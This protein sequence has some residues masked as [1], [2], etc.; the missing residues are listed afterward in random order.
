MS[1]S[2]V[3][4]VITLSG[5]FLNLTIAISSVVELLFSS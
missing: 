2:R 4:N 3:F 5:I 1:A